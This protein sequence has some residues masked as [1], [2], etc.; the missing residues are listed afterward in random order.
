MVE[1]GLAAW[2]EMG[3][4]EFWTQVG[5]VYGR[6]QAKYE[7]AVQARE[8]REITAVLVAAGAIVPEGSDRVSYD[9]H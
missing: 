3:A 8:R 4:D 5:D 2:H 6:D 9:V 1:A 7:A